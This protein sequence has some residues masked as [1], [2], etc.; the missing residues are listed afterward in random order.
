MKTE[1]VICLFRTIYIVNYAGKP[2]RRW[3]HRDEFK[4][5]HYY[6]GKIAGGEN[7]YIKDEVN[8]QRKD[9][10]RPEQDPVHG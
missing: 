6:D 7:Q 9:R 5:G 3:V 1:E 2:F 8:I 4:T 10:E